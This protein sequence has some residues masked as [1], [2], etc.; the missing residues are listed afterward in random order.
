[1]ILPGKRFRRPRMTLG[2]ILASIAVSSIPI[3][4][5]MSSARDGNAKLLPTVI[6]CL[7]ATLAF[8]LLFW[9]VIVPLIPPLRRTLGRPSWSGWELEVHPEGIVWMDDAPSR[10]GDV[11]RKGRGGDEIIFMD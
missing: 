10:V 6:C 4:V 11:R 5:T 8:E 2:Q 9:G 3:S 1:M 7:V